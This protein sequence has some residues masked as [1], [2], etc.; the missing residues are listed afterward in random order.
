[1]LWVPLLKPSHDLFY[2][3]PLLSL[4]LERPGLGIK[5][6]WNHNTYEDSYTGCIQTKLSNRTAGQLATKCE[7][8]W[9]RRTWFEMIYLVSLALSVKSWSDYEIHDPYLQNLN[10]K[11]INQ[12]KGLKLK[13]CLKFYGVLRYVSFWDQV[14]KRN[15][16]R[17][18]T[19]V[20]ILL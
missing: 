10:Q 9:L 3:L 8:C 11:I 12:R 1:M 19:A 15:M 7:L 18:E 4:T 14:S 20:I 5:A 6:H 2:F 17:K 16:Q 13:V